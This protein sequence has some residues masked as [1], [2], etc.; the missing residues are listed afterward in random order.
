[1]NAIKDG[2]PVYIQV[3]EWIENRIIKGVWKTGDQL[4][5]LRE[6]SAEFR[7]NQN[8]IVRTYEAI[9]HDG[10]AYSVRGMGYYVSDC[11]LESILK[12][13]RQ[14]FYNSTLPRFLNQMSALGIDPVEIAKDYFLKLKDN[15]SEP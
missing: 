9:V 15:E 7:V 4:P 10:T 8:T 2:K 6:L 14:E 11:A 13:R 1:M 3:K 5:S 12:R